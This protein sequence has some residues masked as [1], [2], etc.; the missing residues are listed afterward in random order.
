VL[1]GRGADTIIDEPLKPEEAR[2]QTVVTRLRGK[3]Q[4]GPYRDFKTRNVR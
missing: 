4:R 2:S 1:T 3:E